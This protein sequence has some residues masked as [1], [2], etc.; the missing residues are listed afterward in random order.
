MRFDGF[1]PL[2]TLLLA[3]AMTGCGGSK[4]GTGVGES[5]SAQS[6]GGV[7]APVDLPDEVFSE[8]TGGREAYRLIRTADASS[9]ESA[10]EALD[11]RAF[12]LRSEVEEVDPQTG[13]V[14]ARRMRVVR[15]EPREA[16]APER[17]VVRTDSSGS[18][19]FG[20]LSGLFGPDPQSPLERNPLSALLP[21]Q[22]TY[23]STSGPGLYR[24]RMLPDTT[25]GGARAI[26]ARA[27]IEP[28]AGD[29]TI[30][31]IRL[32]VTPEGGE[33]LYAK[34]VRRQDALLF[35][36][37]S[38]T[39]ASIHPTGTGEWMP[40]HL[41]ADVTVRVPF[42]DPRRITTSRQFRSVL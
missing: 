14:R 25:I 15:F 17:T 7:E 8:E 10:Y 42:G 30:R 11:G 24:Y 9:L 29:E 37:R 31:A 19:G 26:G 5:A 38:T 27:R 41:E 35:S 12:T 22:P 18:F 34:I 23:A 28:G 40:A 32:F 39:S 36:E 21:D 2:A 4:D 1:L 3:L 6:E 13:E 20:M 16:D 33:V